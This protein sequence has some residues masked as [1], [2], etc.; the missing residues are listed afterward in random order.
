MVVWLISLVEDA[1]VRCQTD[2]VKDGV[3]LFAELALLRHLRRAQGEPEQGAWE[4][5]LHVAAKGHEGLTLV[6]VLL[7]HRN[8]EVTLQA[9]VAGVDRQV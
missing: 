8:C 6:G 4:G 7:Q 1:S 9:R 3:Y 2:R 5:I